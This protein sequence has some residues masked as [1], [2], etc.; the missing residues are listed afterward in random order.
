MRAYTTHTIKGLEALYKIQLALWT[1]LSATNRQ[2]NAV[3]HKHH[4]QL[5]LAKVHRPVAAIA[6]SIF[7]WQD[8]GLQTTA[9]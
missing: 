4:H 6:V 7:A 2:W 8:L 5:L 3:R 1:P 9:I